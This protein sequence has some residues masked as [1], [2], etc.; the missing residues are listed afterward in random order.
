MG[1]N[2]PLQQEH[3]HENYVESK[4]HPNALFEGRII[5]AVDLSVPGTYNVRAKGRFTLHGS[6]RER[7]IPC[8]IAVDA[9]GLAVTCGFDVPLADHGIRVPRVV[10]Q[11]LA[12]VVRVNVELRMEP[13]TRK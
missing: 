1:F 7:I 12:P 8:R 10:Q 11:K 2:S 5:E 6:A 4:V 13:S 3:F 9:K